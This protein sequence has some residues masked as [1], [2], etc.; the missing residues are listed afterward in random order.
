MK[1]NDSET[2]GNI[3]Q[4][5]IARATNTKKNYTILLY[6]LLVWKCPSSLYK[7]TYHIAHPIVAEKTMSMIE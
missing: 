6:I 4:H 5:E 2:K 3:K 7:V 1:F